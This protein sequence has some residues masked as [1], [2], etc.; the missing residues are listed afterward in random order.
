MNH[1]WWLMNVHCISVCICVHTNKTW[2]PFH[3]SYPESF[4]LSRLRFGE[5]AFAPI[6][7]IVLVVRRRPSPHVLVISQSVDERYK[8]AAINQ[9]AFV[10]VCR[11]FCVCL[12]YVVYVFLCV[13]R[14]RYEAIHMP[15]ADDHG[16]YVFVVNVGAGHSKTGWRYVHIHKGAWTGWYCKYNT[17][18][19]NSSK[20]YLFES[21]HHSIFAIM[22]H[23]PPQEKRLF[24]QCMISNIGSGWC[25][26]PL[27]NRFIR[28]RNLFIFYGDFDDDRH[29]ADRLINM[30]FGMSTST[31]MNIYYIQWVLYSTMKIF[32][33]ATVCFNLNGH[34]FW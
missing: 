27:L 28:N 31:K 14:M 7:A 30:A 13:W 3:I 32:E 11:L 34:C 1:A 21:T 23:S 5:R 22:N 2:F 4:W 15:M 26:R 25:R 18:Y 17:R 10:C 19:P 20:Y 9:F 16:I 12:S 8:S 6:S 33:W 29:L 24:Q